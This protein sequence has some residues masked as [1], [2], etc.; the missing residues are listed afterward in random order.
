M[1]VY[2]QS[3][4]CDD[5]LPVDY[6]FQQGYTIR[7]VLAEDEFSLSYLA[8]EADDKTEVIL[9]EYFPR[10]LSQRDQAS[11]IIAPITV[12]NSQD[13]QWG[14]SQYRDNAYELIDINHPNIVNVRTYFEAHNTVYIVTDYVEGKSLED[15]TKNKALSEIE[16]RSLISPLLDGLQVLHSAGQLHSDLNP[17]NILIQNEISQPVIS[18]LGD[19][20]YIFCHHNQEIAQTVS[21]GYSPCELYYANDK[22]GAWTDIYAMGSILYYLVSGATPNSAASR[23]TSIADQGKDSLEPM[24]RVAD[25]DRYS[26][27]LLIAIDHAMKVQKMDR[28]QSIQ[29]W[30]DELGIQKDPSLVTKNNDDNNQVKPTNLRIDGI[31]ASGIREKNFPEKHTSIDFNEISQLPFEESKPNRGYLGYIMT[32]V[33]AFLVGS[34]LL[35][36]QFQN[37]SELTESIDDNTINLQEVSATLPLILD[38][39]NHTLIDE[40]ISAHLEQNE[41]VLSFQE[42]SSLEGEGIAEELSLFEEGSIAQKMSSSEEDK[43][44]EFTVQK[45]LSSEVEITPLQL[46]D[47]PIAKDNLIAQYMTNSSSFLVSQLFFKSMKNINISSDESR[48]S[49]ILTLKHI[50]RTSSKEP[51]GI[52]IASS[53][54]EKL[55]NTTKKGVNKNR[56]PN[57]EHRNVKTRQQYQGEWIAKQ[58]QLRNPPKRQYRKP[59]KKQ[60]KKQPRR[61]YKKQSKRPLPKKT[62][63]QYQNEWKAKQR[64]LKKRAELKKRK[65][66]LEAKRAKRT[67]KQIEKELLNENDW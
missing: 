26:G 13:Y 57:K 40:A 1:M 65:Q 3:V 24:V 46:L 6:I 10:F 29:I 11:Y 45:I 9:L 37:V 31:P 49:E 56:Y 12:A 17:S 20:K 18:R 59:L 2:S 66:L 33:F 50:I 52:K 63:K 35:W 28:P 39:T 58:K 25:T 23:L 7:Q 62:R 15:F 67:T 38:E 27:Q 44:E 48:D 64:Q 47:V 54:K 34:Y 19:A 22:Q 14:L 43:E 41:S 32:A 21:P 60:Y 53:N 16:I 8:T 42:K 51:D 4:Q 55:G 36:V 30:R 5:A 61:H